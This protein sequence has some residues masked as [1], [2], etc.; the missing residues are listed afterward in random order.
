MYEITVSKTFSAA[1]AL[2]LPDGTFETLHGHDWA[3]K[4]TAAGTELDAMECVMDFHVLVA[5]VDAVIAPWQNENLN[6]CAPF[7]GA[8]PAVPKVNPSAERVAWWI[9]EE[10]KKA[11]PDGVNMVSV[12]VKESPG[13][14]ATYR[15]PP[16]A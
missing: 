2:R 5:A 16:N 4:V 10:V 14:V 9:G 8:T 15:P 1:H 12:A 7:R 6:G 11:L 13:C 3:V